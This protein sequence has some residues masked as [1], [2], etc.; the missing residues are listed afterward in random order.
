VTPRNSA[1]VHLL[2]IASTLIVV[3][4]SKADVQIDP[5]VGLHAGIYIWPAYSNRDEVEAD[6]EPGYQWGLVGGVNFETDSASDEAPAAIDRL[7]TR[8]ELEVGQRFSGLHGINDGPVQRTGDGKNLQA[9]SVSFNLWPSVRISQACRFYA[10]GGGGGTWIRAL[11]SDKRVW[12]AQTG[13]G[14][15]IDVP[16]LGHDA[17]VD[18][19]WRSFFA[20]STKLRDALADFDAHGAILG[21]HFDF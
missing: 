3:H 19:G 7:G 6:A 21:L 2:A 13:L 4:D 17:R 9:T 15:L 16:V 12:S 1:L 14:F 18:L 11:G 10:G 5:Y 20:N 8:L